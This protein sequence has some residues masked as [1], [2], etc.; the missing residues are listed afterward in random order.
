MIS[1]IHFFLV[2]VLTIKHVIYEDKYHLNCA[3]SYFI[4]HRIPEN[5]KLDILI[6]K[7]DKGVHEIVIL[8]FSIW[9]LAV[10]V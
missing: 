6:I 1:V 9:P 3:P 7:I 4:G 5:I 2:W 10:I 8:V